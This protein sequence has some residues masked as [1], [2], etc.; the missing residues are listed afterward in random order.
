MSFHSH[1]RSAVLGAAI[2]I[3][4]GTPA[5]GAAPPAG[6]IKLEEI[7][8][9]AQRAETNLQETPIS[10]AAVSGEQLAQ[11]GASTLLDLASFIPNLQVGSTTL[12][13]A[14]NGRFAIRGIG[15]EA[16]TQASVG[17]YIDEVYYP[18]GAGNLMG[19]FDVDRV[20]VL[21][22]PQGTLFGR[23]TI[24][25]AIQ[26]VTVQPGREFGGYGEATL[27]NFGRTDFNGALNIPLGETLA[28]RVAVGYNSRDGYVHDDLRN[29]DRGDDTRKAG[30]VQVRWTPTS[31]L[32]LDLKGEW[33]STDNNGRA[34]TIHGYAG[35]VFP[36]GQNDGAQF[37]TLGR[38]LSA[39]P[40]NVHLCPAIGA[41][42]ASGPCLDAASTGEYQV[43]GYNADEFSR[44][45]YTSGALVANWT[46]SE[47]ATLKSITG[48]SLTKNNSAVD[49]DSTPGSFFACVTPKNDTTAFSEE[50]QLRLNLADGRLRWTTGLFYY[51]QEL[52]TLTAIAFG[53]GT[54]NPA[55]ATGNKNGLTSRALF[56][57]ASFDFTDRLSGTVGLRY[58]EEEVTSRTLTATGILGP[59]VKAKF[60]DTSPQF[61]E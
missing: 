17:L 14:G 25:G 34:S 42:P 50:L 45:D 13:G 36:N 47:A 55:N 1:G 20:E 4:L 32:T 28:A 7:V 3:I 9:T 59:Q 46:L 39:T 33:L 19:L 2:G 18:T 51:D 6:G 35:S 43:A 27:G 53:L 61:I 49:Y 58:S 60:T 24:G 26:Y 44:L 11:Q 41:P 31:N 16:G 21:R 23:N 40:Y 48:Y 12:Q 37:T 38:I 56:S 10:V 57:Q 15:Q 52:K 5:F 29:V 8:V 30:R 54:P 22:G